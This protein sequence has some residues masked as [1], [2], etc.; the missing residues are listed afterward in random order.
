MI[1]VLNTK[2]IYN[3]Q[4]LSEKMFSKKYLRDTK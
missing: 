4:I 3:L 1:N 2:I